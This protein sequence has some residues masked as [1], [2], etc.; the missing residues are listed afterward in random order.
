MS[1]MSP[2][3]AGGFLTTSATWETPFDY[4]TT[5]KLCKRLIQTLTHIHPNSLPQLLPKGKPPALDPV[6]PTQTLHT[7]RS[8]FS[9]IRKAEHTN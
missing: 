5:T 2:A 4:Y 8:Y 1:P 9:W 6:A 3:L 7:R